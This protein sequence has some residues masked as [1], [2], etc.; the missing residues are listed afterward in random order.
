MVLALALG[1]VVN[2]AVLGVGPDC[3]GKDPRNVGL[4]LVDR[5]HDDVARRL[6]VELLDALPRSVSM[7]SIP[8]C[9]RNGRMS[10]SSVNIDLI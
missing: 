6:V 8:R 3:F 5:R 9:S 2:V 4:E 1:E 7:I 10:H